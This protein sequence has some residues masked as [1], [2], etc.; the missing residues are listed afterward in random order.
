MSVPFD[1]IPEHVWDALAWFAS[2]DNSTPPDPATVRA[3]VALGLLYGQ[4]I[5]CALRRH[6]A[7]WSSMW[8]TH[9]GM[10]ALLWRKEQLRKRD[11]GQTDGQAERLPPEG[12]KFSEEDVPPPFREGG[13]P[14]G[15][16]LTSDYL[17]DSTDW[18]LR[19]SYLS[20][21]RGPGKPLT[22]FIKVGRSYAYLFKEVAALRKLKTDKQAE[23]ERGP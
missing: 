15:E 20:K 11:D 23:R 14:G 1:Q 10:A 16:V 18:D 2:G 4:A 6:P 5:Q 19:I 12:T 9:R 21:N 22:T 17:K 8:I 7:Q 13:K 3:A